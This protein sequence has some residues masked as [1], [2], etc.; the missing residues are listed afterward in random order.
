LSSIFSHK[1]IFSEKLLTNAF[2]YAIINI[3]FL[4]KA[5]NGMFKNQFYHQT[6]KQNQIFITETAV[7][8]SFSGRFIR[9]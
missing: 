5:V 2:F 6:Q 4:R 8:H 1:K 7:S 3:K 9:I